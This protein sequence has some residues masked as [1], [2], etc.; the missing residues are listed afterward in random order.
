MGTSLKTL[1]HSLGVVNFAAAIYYDL[2][3]VSYPP[4][5]NHPRYKF[6]GVW[7]YLTFLNLCLQ[8][9][10]FTISLLADIIQ[11]ERRTGLSRIR[12]VIFASLAFPMGVSTAAIFWGLFTVNRE[13]V[14]KVK[15]APYLPNWL[16]HSMHTWMVPL[17]LLDL[18]LVRHHFP[19]RRLGAGIT[20]AAIAAYLGW[21]LYINMVAGFWVYPVL[22][23]LSVEA[24]TVFLVAC[25]LLGVVVYLLGEA[26]NGLVWNRR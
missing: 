25:S 8:L 6:G 26:V 1:V 24:R 11:G 16:N 18:Y 2:F 23:V 9:I 3:V 12:D 4:H 10:Y 14:F 5:L 15:F 7:K 19:S 22:K 20:A 21:I 13:L 17:L